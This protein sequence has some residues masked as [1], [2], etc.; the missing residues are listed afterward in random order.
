MSYGKDASEIVR[1]YWLNIL[2]WLWKDYKRRW[3]NKEKI[4]QNQVK[5]K[6]SIQKDAFMWQGG[7]KFQ[8]GEN[9]IVVLHLIY[10]WNSPCNFNYRL[11]ILDFLD[12]KINFINFFISFR[13]TNHSLLPKHSLLSCF[14]SSTS[15]ISFQPFQLLI[16]IYSFNIS[17]SNKPFKFEV[18]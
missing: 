18:A 15:S 16:L 1:F 11:L 13:M 12:A 17:S 7:L 6:N 10:Y 3:K 4:E 2:Q 9:L 5:G 14:F 8:F